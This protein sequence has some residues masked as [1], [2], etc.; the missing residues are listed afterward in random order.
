M[1]TF[2]KNKGIKGLIFAAVLSVLLFILI[3]TKCFFGMNNFFMDRIYQLPKVKNPNIYIVGIDEKTL[4]DEGL[5]NY[6]SF[7]RSYYKQVI[8]NTNGGI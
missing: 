1:R 4:G 3:M 5:G 2:I 8:E 7:R 6:N